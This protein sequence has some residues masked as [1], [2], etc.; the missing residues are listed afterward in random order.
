MKLIGSLIVWRGNCRLSERMRLSMHGCILH[1]R[2]RDRDMAVVNQERRCTLLTLN[3]ISKVHARVWIRVL[4]IS[5]DSNFNKFKNHIKISSWVTHQRSH[6]MLRHRKSYLHI[7]RRM[8]SK[9]SESSSLR[10]IRS[11]LVMEQ[12]K[13]EGE[14]NRTD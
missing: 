8:N 3:L 2:T 4:L 1:T 12:K 10:R 9:H 7:I 5:I 6:N 13:E 11:W 14:K